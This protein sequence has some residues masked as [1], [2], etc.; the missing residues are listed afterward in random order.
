MK[1]RL[2]LLLV[3]LACLTAGDSL[4]VPAPGTALPPPSTGGLSA[5]DSMVAKLATHRRVLV[6]AA[7]PDDE[8]TALLTL[9]ARGMGGESAYLSLSRGDG[10]QNLIG[11][12]LGPGLG[13]IRTQELNAA[14]NLDG[15]RQYFTRAYDFGFSKSV[16][17]TFKFWPRE[18]I[19]KDAVRIVRRFRP[20]VM[21]H[22][23][24]G[25]PP[26][27]GRG[28]TRPR[29][30]AARGSSTGN[31]RPSFFRRAE[32]SRSRDAPFIRSPSRAAAFNARRA[33]AR[34]SRSARTTRGRPGRPGPEGP[35][36]KTSSERSIPA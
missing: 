3:I 35:R 23:F 33:P 20:Q 1:R 8:D 29:S 13:L 28:A 34:S 32:S 6:V 26:K 14:R 24:S 10:G 15:A 5:L 11:D 31:P 21:V 30:P 22:V 19:L 12:E 27:P 16:E 7:H 36:R 4:G 18:E 17:E 9:V 25:F 2:L